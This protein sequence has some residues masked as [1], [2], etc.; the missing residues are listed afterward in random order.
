M[1]TEPIVPTEEF[2]AVAR[3]LLEK[4]K[5]GEAN[6]EKVSSEDSTSY[7]LDLDDAAVLL[8]YHKPRALLGSIQ[9]LLSGHGTSAYD[10]WIVHAPD[11]DEPDGGVKDWEL[12][13]SLFAEVH[14]RVSGLGR[15]LKSVKDA[16]A[17][18]GVIG[19]TDRR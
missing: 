18:P 11:P 13:Q 5:A 6:W 12:V 7:R 9:L 1:S 16:I 14:R 8:S 10:S 3:G 17:K 2:R 4:T 15:V 19:A